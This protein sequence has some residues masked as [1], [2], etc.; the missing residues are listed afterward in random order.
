MHRNMTRFVVDKLISKN[1]H[2][3]WQF[4]LDIFNVN[5]RL[6]VKF[7]HI[8]LYTQLK[9]VFINKIRFSVDSGEKQGISI[10]KIA[11]YKNQ[12]FLMGEW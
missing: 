1:L 7:C 3:F 9:N 4:I 12:R 10:R 6:D 8:Y 2:I 11:V 5:S